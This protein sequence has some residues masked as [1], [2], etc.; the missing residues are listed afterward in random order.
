MREN[1]RIQESARV[2]WE[3]NQK[4][5]REE[6]E[7]V[8]TAS[9]S[10]AG[11]KKHRR[12]RR[13]FETIASGSI[14]KSSGKGEVVDLRTPSRSP[15]IECLTPQAGQRRTYTLTPDSTASTTSGDSTL[16]EGTSDIAIS[17]LHHLTVSL[18]SLASGSSSQAQRSLPTTPEMLLIYTRE[19]RPKKQ[20]S[21]SITPPQHIQPR[22]PLG[23]H[24]KRP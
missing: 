9:T 24:P 5:R 21:L 12:R 10:S 6:R 8:V 16:G 4:R 13:V 7:A 18:A 1:K 15:S 3:K 2:E 22:T 14:G 19:G 17:S 23:R 11:K 20:W